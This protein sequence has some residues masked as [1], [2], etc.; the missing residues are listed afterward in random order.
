ME[1]NTGI[2]LDWASEV[3]ARKV[4]L[5]LDAGDF[6]AGTGAAENWKGQ[7]S[8]NVVGLGGRGATDGETSD[9]VLI[10]ASVVG[11][12]DGE[13]SDLALTGVSAAG[14]A[15]PDDAEDGA[16]TGCEAACGSAAAADEA[17][18]PMPV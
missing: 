9:L 18:G 4:A 13:I 3:L 17:S 6:S 14:S 16:A 7:G 8:R 10:G 5:V 11:S 2:L 1:K 15:V 12:A